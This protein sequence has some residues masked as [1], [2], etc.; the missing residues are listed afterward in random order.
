MQSDVFI[1]EL[2]IEKADLRNQKIEEDNQK[3]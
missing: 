3:I 2:N 1:Q